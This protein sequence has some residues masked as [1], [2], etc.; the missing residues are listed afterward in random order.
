[1]EKGERGL[2]IGKGKGTELNIEIKM[3]WLLLFYR[4]TS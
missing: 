3:S 2:G 1:M 4:T